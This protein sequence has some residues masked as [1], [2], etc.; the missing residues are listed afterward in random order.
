MW[1]SWFQCYL[2]RIVF[3]YVWEYVLVLRGLFV[4]WISMQKV[5]ALNGEFSRDSVYGFAN[6]V[7]AR[8]DSRHPPLFW[9]RKKDGKNVTRFHYESMILSLWCVSMGLNFNSIFKYLANGP[10]NCISRDS[11]LSSEQNSSWKRMKLKRPQKIRLRMRG[12]MNHEWH[13][14][15]TSFSPNPKEGF[16]RGKNY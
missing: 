11:P 3:A 5:S 15:C 13:L 6:H 2:I 8:H 7:K 4:Y 1:I 14:Y 9:K 16:C 10:R 12:V